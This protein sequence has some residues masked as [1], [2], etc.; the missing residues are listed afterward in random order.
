VTSPRRV[1]ARKRA[2]K[3]I[4]DRLIEGW[5]RKDADIGRG[6]Q[7]GAQYGIVCCDTTWVNFKV[8]AKVDRVKKCRNGNASSICRK[9]S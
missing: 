6:Q 2:E 4:V 7:L 8:C 5:L 9:A 1:P 3:R